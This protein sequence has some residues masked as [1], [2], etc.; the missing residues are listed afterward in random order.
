[1]TC[2]MKVFPQCNPEHPAPA[3]PLSSLLPSTVIEEANM[4]ITPDSHKRNA[5]FNHTRHLPPPQT[6][7]T[8]LMRV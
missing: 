1:M 6:V 2:Y 4:A 5:L 7:D 8:A 3:G